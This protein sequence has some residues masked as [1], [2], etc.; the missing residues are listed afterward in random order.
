MKNKKILIIIL[1]AI[2]ILIFLILL[3]L[4]FSE[5]RNFTD[6]IKALKAQLYDD[7]SDKF[8]I[9]LIEDPNDAKT[10]GAFLLSSAL[11]NKIDKD[12]ILEYFQKY[13][14]LNTYPRFKFNF[15]SREYFNDYRFFIESS[16]REIRE[17][18][19]NNG[20]R[21][22]S[23]E[24]VEKIVEQT[25]NLIFYRLKPY[26]PELIPYVACS[27]VILARKGD[28]TASKFLIDLAI[29]KSEYV[30]F[31]ALVGQPMI[32]YLSEELKNKESL[33]YN[34]GI[35]VLRELKLR[36]KIT[37]LIKKHP[38][39]RRPY[40][41]D[42]PS[43]YKKTFAYKFENEKQYKQFKP[44]IFMLPVADVDP[45]GF[46]FQINDYAENLIGSVISYD[47]RA[48][49]FIMKLYFWSQDEWKDARILIGNVEYDVINFKNYPVLIKIDPSRNIL[50]IG[51]GEYKST[52]IYE[53]REKRK[54][55]VFSPE[56]GWQE[57]IEVDTLIIGYKEGFTI[58]RW[59]IYDINSI[60]LT[61]Q[62]ISN[63][64]DYRNK[65]RQKLEN[66]IQN[67]RKEKDELTLKLTPQDTASAEATFILL[68]DEPDLGQKFG[69]IEPKIDSI[70]G[71]LVCILGVGKIPGKDPQYPINM[72]II[73]KIKPDSSYVKELN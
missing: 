10:K 18:M 22:D 39:I 2:F 58:E 57:K 9:C 8:K 48:K 63:S 32:K 65:I 47:D 1:P 53:V 68:K 34:D 64:Y 28:R 36:S 37:D 14:I 29:E 33:L 31:L 11:K 40:P 52:P 73:K 46:D 42:D 62:L 51:F 61:A 50:L 21:T 25:S 44:Q 66:I 19:K 41:K 71:N 35:K 60:S 6:G 43:E 49:N 72:Y 17:I 69:Y 45:A 13:L 59:D 38:E 30:N 7:A 54:G 70:K 26:T 4:F 20:I 24:E 56:L 5:S 16:K 55:L 3:R 12:L 15:S 67:A 23:W 27:A